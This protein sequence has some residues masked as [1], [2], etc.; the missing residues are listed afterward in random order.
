MTRPAVGELKL[1]GGHQVL[2]FVNTVDNR[3]TP[4]A[5]V[6]ALQSYED[7]IAWSLRA[8]LLT[9]PEAAPLRERARVIPARANTALLR[10]KLLR[11]PLYRLFCHPAAARAADLAILEAEHQS[12]ESA[13]FLA[14]SGVGFTWQWREADP[15]TI[16]HRLAVAAT[17]LLTSGDLHRMITCAGD[18]CGWLRL[19]AAQ[20]EQTRWCA[21]EAC[22]KQ[23]PSLKKRTKK[24]LRPAAHGRAARDAAQS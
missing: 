1:L 15:D 18:A 24:L 22:R 13:R 6:D 16:T 19:T 12:A 5:D 3:V 4:S 23:S 17:A 7:L 2:D 14:F 9:E 11:E 20:A 10:A 21:G 8:G